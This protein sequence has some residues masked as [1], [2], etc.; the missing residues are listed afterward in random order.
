MPRT[1]ADQIA[2]ALFKTVIA[3]CFTGAFKGKYFAHTSASSLDQRVI[4]P[5]WFIVA[6]HS[7]SANVK[8]SSTRIHCTVTKAAIESTLFKSPPLSSLFKSGEGIQK[9]WWDS[10]QE[11]IPDTLTPFLALHGAFSLVS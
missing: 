9:G 5:K 8:R 3:Y 11:G 10:S 2:V 4:F 7:H 1:T 6:R